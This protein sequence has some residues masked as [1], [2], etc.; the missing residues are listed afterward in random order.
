MSSSKSSY[1]V[2]MKISSLIAPITDSAPHHSINHRDFSCCHVYFGLYKV[3]SGPSCTSRSPT[4]ILTPLFTPQDNLMRRLWHV[5]IVCSTLDT[6]CAIFSNEEM[7]QTR[8]PVSDRRLRTLLAF[9]KA[10]SLIGVICLDMHLFAGTLKDWSVVMHTGRPVT[11]VLC[12]RSCL[13][14][15]TSQHT[16]GDLL[17]EES[18]SSA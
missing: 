4:R 2:A 3:T 13:S 8:V 11:D 6:P 1:V 9:F 16:G 7:L 17:R 15:N 18:K 10:L 12:R 14:C 5:P